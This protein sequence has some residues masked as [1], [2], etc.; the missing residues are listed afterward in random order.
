MVEVHGACSEEVAVERGCQCM[1]SSLE[2]PS[3]GLHGDLHRFIPRSIATKKLVHDWDMVLAQAT[4]HG[5]ESSS[6]RWP[7]SG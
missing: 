1:G 2:G 7:R 3:K 5:G 4:E 6:K